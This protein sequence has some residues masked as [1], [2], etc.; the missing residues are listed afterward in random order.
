MQSNPA[1][2]LRW[3]ATVDACDDILRDYLACIGDSAIQV[4]VGPEFFDHVDLHLDT[5][6]APLEVSRTDPDHDVARAVGDLARQLDRPIPQRYRRIGD[7]QSEQGH[8]RR[9]DESGD[10]DIGAGWVELAG[11]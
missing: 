11:G 4:G 1:A 3:V 10:K 2:L 9:A 6:T 5:K 7:R 8:R